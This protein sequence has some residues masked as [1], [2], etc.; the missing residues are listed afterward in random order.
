MK[1]RRTGDQTWVREHNLSIILTQIW[2][3]RSPIRRSHLTE[4]C[5]LNKSTVG[6]LIN[7]L[8]ELNFVRWVGFEDTTKIINL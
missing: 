6:S 7:E 3:A 1:V 5:G 8:L 4:I 2:H